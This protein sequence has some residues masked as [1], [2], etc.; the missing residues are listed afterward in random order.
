MR[1]KGEKLKPKNKKWEI[2]GRRLLSPLRELSP[3]VLVCVA[4][5][6]VVRFG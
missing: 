5:N 3:V 1:E 6:D 2:E 4:A